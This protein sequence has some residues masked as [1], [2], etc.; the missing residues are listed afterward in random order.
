MLRDVS[1]EKGEVF[2]LGASHSNKGYHSSPR[3]GGGAGRLPRASSF[4][5]GWS[6]QSI[7][8]FPLV[9]GKLDL[10]CENKGVLCPISLVLFFLEGLFSSLRTKTLHVTSGGMEHV[11]SQLADNKHMVRQEGVR[12][13]KE[14]LSSN[15]VSWALWKQNIQGLMNAEEWQA[16]E[17]GFLAATELASALED[18]MMGQELLEEG[19]AHIEDPEFR[20]RLAVCTLIKELIKQQGLPAFQRIKD[21]LFKSIAVNFQRGEE[22]KRVLQIVGATGLRRSLQAK[23]EDEDDEDNDVDPQAKSYTGSYMEEDCSQAGEEAN[24]ENSVPSEYDC[25]DYDATLRMKCTSLQHDAEGWHA[26]ETSFKCLQLVVAGLGPAMASEIT[27]GFMRMLYRAAV[28]TNRF[29][30]ESAHYT[31]AALS[32]AFETA[33][34]ISMGDD[35][36]LSIAQGMGDHWCQVRYAACVAARAFMLKV[37]DDARQFY[38]RMVPRLCMNRHYGAEG[39]KQYSQETWRLVMGDHGRHAIAEVM[40][41]V[42]GFL[43]SQAMT[44][45]HIVREAACQC[46]AELAKRLEPQ[47]VSAHVTPFLNALIVAFRDES[48]PVRDAVS[49]ACADLTV[50]HPE[51]CAGRIP[52]MIPFWYSALVDPVWSLR[53]TAA[54]SLA[55][56]LKVHKEFLDPVKAKLQELLPRYQS[57]PC[58]SADDN[59]VQFGVA[60]NKR[61]EAKRK[62]DNDP[63]LHE[64]QQTFSCGSLAPK[65]RAGCSCNDGIVTKKAQ[66]WEE[67]DGALY[68]LRELSSMA[69]EFVVNLLPS[70][71]D[72]AVADHFLQYYLLW[73]TVWKVAPVVMKNVG[74]RPFKRHMDSLLPGLEKALQDDNLLASSTAAFAAKEMQAFVGPSIFRG[75]CNDNLQRLLDTAPLQPP[76]PSEQFHKA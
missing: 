61:E 41:Q 54:I 28:H 72:I 71:A 38:P 29:V 12:G 5:G 40:E 9:V 20:V 63:S 42:V 7:G 17:G 64:Q 69:P 43:I 6:I 56:M 13:L 47:V 65:S 27:P 49:I 23:E 16:R 53:E 21:P 1:S 75:H 19:I 4:R 76:F 62:R 15:E 22:G 14:Y 3:G 58:E 36:S 45:N 46:I 18:E 32:E 70:L 37:G 73:E 2:L 34:L 52:E 66:P 35:F 26:L 51:L 10:R 60:K 39:V 44:D 48:W 24:A 68:L 8:V 25:T 33:A 11:L 57:Q 74:K 30:R 50:A 59:R 67:T 55:T 31:F